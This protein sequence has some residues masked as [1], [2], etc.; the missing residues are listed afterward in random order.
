MT[1]QPLII[2]SNASNTVGLISMHNPKDHFIA[3]INPLLLKQWAEMVYEQFPDEDVVY[4]SLHA[5]PDPMNTARHLAAAA[6]YG[7][8]LQVM[9]CGCDCDDVVK[10]GGKKE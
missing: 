2:L 7:D 4:I 9:V 3:E 1:E 5:H 6:E 10:K 8:E